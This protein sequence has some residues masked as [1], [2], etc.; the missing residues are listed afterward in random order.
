MTFKKEKV[1]LKETVILTPNEINYDINKNIM[2]YLK[3]N[4]EKKCNQYGYILKIENIIKKSQGLIMPHDFTGNI[5]FQVLVECEAYRPREADIIRDCKINMI[6]KIGIFASKDFLN[7]IITS[8]NNILPDDYNEKYKI[9]QLINV[10]V[11]GSKFDLYDNKITILGKIQY[12]SVKGGSLTTSLPNFT[13]NPMK[14][15]LDNSMLESLEFMEN[16]TDNLNHNSLGYTSQLNKIK[17]LIDPYYKKGLWQNFKYISNPYELLSPNKV[18]KKGGSS[19]KVLYGK[20]IPKINA[21]NRAFFKFIEMNE[22]FNILPPRQKMRVAFLAEGPGGFIQAVSHLRSEF[23]DDQ[24]F[25][26]TLKSDNKHLLFNEKLVKQC[27][28]THPK[29]LQIKYYD[30]CNT[31]NALKFIK[32]CKKIDL[33]TAD[34]GFEVEEYDKQEQQSL[35][36]IFHQL[37]IALSIQEKGGHFICKI[38]SSTT[39]P[40]LF[41]IMMCSLYYDEVYIT[42]PLTSRPMNSEKYIVAK[43]FKGIS[44]QTLDWLESISREWEKKNKIIKRFSSIPFPN[45]LIQTMRDYNKKINDDQIH[46]IYDTICLIDT[47]KYNSND[48]NKLCFAE[49]KKEQEKIASEWCL[50]NKINI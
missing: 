32:K 42:K 4:L 2:N 45:E 19:S 28:E 13:S 7:I 49:Y 16:D 31:D 6:N 36:L 17:N 39:Y 18:K 30:I 24:Y 50:K 35:K 8:R 9:G 43:N 34:G 41:I 25:A 47:M 38:F 14:E 22:E 11:L 21:I 1:I 33:V 37:W 3:I 23:E 29:L 12:Y 5:K 27:E 26:V 10:F 44:K 40:T 15:I 46:S 20:K 48:T